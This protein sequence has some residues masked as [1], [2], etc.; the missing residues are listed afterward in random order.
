M[1]DYF[2]KLRANHG[3]NLSQAVLI[4]EQRGLPVSRGVLRWLE[5]GLTKSLEPALLRALGKLY[6]EPYGKLVQEVA[7][8]VYAITPHELL[9]GTPPPTAVEGFIAL[10]VLAKP[11][12]HRHPLLVTLDPDHDTQ[13]A[14][15]RDFV[16]G[17]TRPIGVRV[18]RKLASMAPTI[19]PDDVVLLDQN[20]TRRRRPPAG[21]IYAI[22]MGPLTGKVGGTLHRV[23]LS[24]RTLVLSSDNPN[25]SA[26]PTRTFDLTGKHL[27]DILVGEVVWIGR[28][29]A[30][31]TAP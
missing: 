3:W 18:G 22:T 14:F 2:R 10:P 4:A 19:E 12:A 23:D 5:G 11:I 20:V 26:Y 6:G 8:H 15:P 27:V 13:L 7:R 16:T 17:F 28:V 1:G 24:G 31:P 9:E 30:R 21:R 25:K 29:L